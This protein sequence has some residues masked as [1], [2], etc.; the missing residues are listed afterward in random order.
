MRWD[1]VHRNYITRIALVIIIKYSIGRDSPFNF[2]KQTRFSRFPHHRGGNHISRSLGK[3]LLS[4]ILLSLL[5][6]CIIAIIVIIFLFCLS[7][8]L[9]Y[10]KIV[11]CR[12]RAEW[13][14]HYYTGRLTWEC[15]YGWNLRSH[16]GYKPRSPV[17]VGRAVVYEP[18]QVVCTDTPHAAAV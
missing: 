13:R 11:G 6:C 12:A 18:P 8:L 3:L 1:R 10:I 17:A 9:L 15:R 14:R 16:G 4:L 2:I 5:F 7:L